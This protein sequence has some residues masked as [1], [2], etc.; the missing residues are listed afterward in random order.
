MAVERR[1]KDDRSLRVALLVA[2]AL[3]LGAPSLGARASRAG[4]PGMDPERVRQALRSHTLRTVE[5]RTLALQSLRGEVVVVNFWAS[6]CSP[7]RKELPRLDALHASIAGRGGRVLAV[8]I[9]SEART[10]QRFARTHRLKLPVY[11]DGPDGLARTLD[12]PHVPFT[13]VLD[14]DG[15]VAL[16]TAGA[17]DHALEAIA[18]TTRRLMAA[19]PAGSPTFAAEAP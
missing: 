4:G 16:T 2:V 19:A 3:G 7:C 17:D 12:L 6:W 5:G 13:I 8:S 10:V 9:D 11:H 15:R 18:A 14:R 1:G